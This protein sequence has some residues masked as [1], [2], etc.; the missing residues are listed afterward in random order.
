MHRILCSFVATL[1]LAVAGLLPAPEALAQKAPD[2]LVKSVAEDVL[3]IVRQDR[4]LR[5]GDNSRM[6]QLIEEKIV[7]H[8][9][10]ERMTRLAVGRSWRQATPEQRQQ[11]IDEFRRLLVR[12]YSAAYSTYNHIVVEVKPLKLQPGEEDVQVKT[13]IK[14]PGGAPPVSVDYSMV[15]NS[16]DWK[17][18]DVVVDGISLVTT[19]RTTFAEEVN[20]GGIEGLL[21]SLAALNAAKT[22]QRPVGATRRQ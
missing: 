7:P 10:F 19:Y 2:E 18:Y 4:A 16:P 5:E 12:S 8:F 20:K 13:L 9:D 14:L 1:L 15:N 21:K 22:A 6:A 17:V 11:L 3:A